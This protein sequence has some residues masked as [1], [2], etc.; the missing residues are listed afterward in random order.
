[1]P[2]SWRTFLFVII[3]LLIEGWVVNSGGE[4]VDWD[5]QLA[6]L[7]DYDDLVE[8]LFRVE[9]DGGNSSIDINLFSTPVPNVGDG[10]GNNNETKHH[11]NTTGHNEDDDTTIKKRWDHLYPYFVVAGMLILAL[12]VRIFTVKVSLM[13]LGILIN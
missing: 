9:G 10:K 4:K 5:D 2:K 6:G 11:H 1:M 8:D 13:V 12:G 3:I 7:S